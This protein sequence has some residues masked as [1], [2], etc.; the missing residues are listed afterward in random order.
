[1][2]ESGRLPL[3]ERLSQSWPKEGPHLIWTYRETGVGYSGPATGLAVGEQPPNRYHLYIMGARGDSEYLL[4][5][6]ART[7]KELWASRIGP[8][9]TFKGNEWGD[10]PRA[11]PTLHDIGAL[12]LVYAQGAQGEL[13]CFNGDKGDVRWR[14]SLLKKLEGEISPLG[15]NTWTTGWGFTCSPLVDGKM[16]NRHVGGPSGP[17]VLVPTQLICVPGGKKGMLAAL[18]LDT[19]KVTWRS[20]DLTYAAPYSSPVGGGQMVIQMT[21]QGVAGVS[22]EDGHLL[23]EYK[24]SQPYQDVV[25]PTPIWHYETTGNESGTLYVYITAGYGAGCDLIKLKE[26]GDRYKVE[27][28]YSNKIMVNQQGGV[29]LVGDHVYGYSEG[30][31][32]VCQDFKTGKLVWN[33]KR[34][35]GRGS[36]IFAD[37]NLYCYT[38]DDGIVALVEA[39]P[40]GYHEISRFQIPERSKLTKPSGK[41]WTHPVIANGKLYLRDQE[42]LFCYDLRGKQ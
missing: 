13:V 29:V 9:F 12:S 38:E 19:G 6:N 33:E 25:I 11:T 23:W 1:L 16:V 14:I 18:D 7:G 30:K 36:V 40:K 41:I 31:G 10:G 22:G 28:V 26:D 24:R 27:K 5:L 37:G 32:W 17:D 15:G 8:T 2:D 34:K 35:L 42:L 39:T 20:E 3:A 4:C 21:D